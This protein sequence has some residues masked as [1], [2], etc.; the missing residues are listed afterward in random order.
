MTSTNPLRVLL[1]DDS[2]D[3]AAFMEH[4]LRRPGSL[5]RYVLSV[6]ENG[7]DGV[8]RCR[9]DPPDCLM[10]DHGLPDMSGLE[11]LAALGANG[12]PPHSRW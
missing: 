2:P 9:L 5:R 10:L 1:V 6:L 8:E 7:T 11:V 12:G 3:D 4:C